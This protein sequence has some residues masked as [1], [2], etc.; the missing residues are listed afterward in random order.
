[1]L[2][3]EI[4]ADA[5]DRRHCMS[6]IADHQQTRPPPLLQ[7]IDGNRQELDIVP[8]A[9]FP[10]PILHERGDRCDRLVQG[11]EALA[12]YLIE[13]TLVDDQRALPVVAAIDHHEDT[14]S[15]DAAQRLRAIT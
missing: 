12:L 15:A 3:S 5:A 14:A 10:E 8:T 13:A 4:D 1:V 11:I 7:P 9:D 2:N 6:G